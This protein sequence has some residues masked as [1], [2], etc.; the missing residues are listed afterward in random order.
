MIQIATIS[1]G[2]RNEDGLP[3]AKICQG[4]LVYS[5]I[6]S[7]MQCIQFLPIAFFAVCVCVCVCVCACVCVF[8]RLNQNL[9]GS[10]YG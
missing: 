1:R 8:I 4:V 7:E 6:L 2:V 10:M 5:L 3:F 9:F